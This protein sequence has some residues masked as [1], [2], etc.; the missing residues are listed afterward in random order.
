MFVFVVVLALHESVLALS[1]A[2]TS[3]LLQKLL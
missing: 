3:Q 2:K 1:P